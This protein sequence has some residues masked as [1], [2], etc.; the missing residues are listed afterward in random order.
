MKLLFTV[1]LITGV[2]AL[3]GCDEDVATTDTTGTGGMTEQG[4]GGGVGTT[5]GGGA[6]GGAG[7]LGGAGGAGGAGGGGG[8]G[9]ACLDTSEHEAVFSIDHASLCLV[10]KFTAPFEVGFA[11]SP[12]WGRHGGPVTLVQA[13]DLS[14][15]PTDEVTITRWSVPANTNESLSAFA[16]L[17]PFSLSIPA[18]TSGPFL[19]PVVVDL[20][21]SSWSVVGWT[22]DGAVG[23]VI[24]LDDTTIGGRWDNVGYFDAVAVDDGTN[25]RLLHTSA[26]AAG[27]GDTGNSAAGLYAAEFCPGP[28]L[29]ATNPTATV[30]TWGTNTGPVARDGDGN[31]FAITTDFGGG[32]QELRGFE[33]SDVAPG[34]GA[35]TGAT[36][37][38]LN[39]FGAALATV[40]TGGNKGLVLFQPQEFT[41]VVENKPLVAQG[42]KVTGQ[43]LSADGAD[44]TA[45]TLVAADAVTLMNDDAGRVW[46]GVVTDTGETT[47]YVLDSA[48]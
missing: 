41:T 31:V 46:M 44:A 16:T 33:A 32:D 37:L 34:G 2:I 15:N 38:T 5:G 28:M 9:T 29:C 39:G 7:G 26:T 25:A 36:L 23:E 48:N 42:Y 24:T 22:G 13:Y 40:K 11:I 4:G 47:F 6:T 30:D 3:T 8:M 45:I 10:D 43:G 17:G 21:L 18:Q 19:S 1:T 35:V 27:D 12:R 14:F 20:P